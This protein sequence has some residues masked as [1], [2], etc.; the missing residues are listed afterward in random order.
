MSSNL[1]PQAEPDGKPC[2]KC[3]ERPRRDGQKTCTEC[4]RVYM[5]DYMQRHKGGREKMNKTK[6]FQEGAQ[7]MR[8]TIMEGL[9]QQNPIGLIS[10]FEFAKWIN[11]LPL[12]R[13]AEDDEG[14]QSDQLDRETP[15]S[16]P[17]GKTPTEE[18]QSVS[19]TGAPTPKG[20]SG[21][22]HSA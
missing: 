5:K 18:S 17:R 3:G 1:E 4:H 15:G 20:S 13:P 11:G 22:L 8:N 19:A 2:V 14:A 6:G 9:G 21:K 12:P 10:V 16:V 7:A